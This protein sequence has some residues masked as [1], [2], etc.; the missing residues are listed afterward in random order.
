M[1]AIINNYGGFNL[2]KQLILTGVTVST[3]WVYRL[4][5]LKGLGMKM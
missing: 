1:V 2:N 5:H 4:E 3:F